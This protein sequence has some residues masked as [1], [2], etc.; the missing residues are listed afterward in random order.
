MDGES[1]N[2]VSILGLLGQKKTASSASTTAVNLEPL[3]P[4]RNNNNNNNNKQSNPVDTNNLYNYQGMAASV[5]NVEN[6]HHSLNDSSGKYVYGTNDSSNESTI[7]QSK[8]LKKSVVPSPNINLVLDSNYTPPVNKDGNPIFRKKS[9]HYQ[10]LI[11]MCNAKGW[12]EQLP[13]T[14]HDPDLQ[15]FCELTGFDRPQ[16]NRKFQEYRKSQWIP[17]KAKQRRQKLQL[18]KKVEL[19]VKEHQ[20]RRDKLKKKIQLADTIM[21]VFQNVDEAMEKAQKEPYVE[22]PKTAKRTKSNSETQQLKST[23]QPRTNVALDDKAV[24]EDK[25]LVA[26]LSPLPFTAEIEE[27]QHQQQQQ[28]LKALNLETEASLLLPPPPPTSPIEATSSTFSDKS[29]LQTLEL[30]DTEM[31]Q[32]H[33]NDDPLQLLILDRNSSWSSATSLT[34]QP[35]NLKQFSTEAE[36]KD[37]TMIQK[38]A[39]LSPNPP[40]DNADQPPP[41]S[42]VSPPL[43]PR[44]MAYFT[45]QQL[46]LHQSLYQ[47]QYQH[48][49]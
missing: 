36:Q 49:P 30:H 39:S 47:D 37:S 1:N 43:S 3:S 20:Q 25:P 19:A 5:D 48:Q 32:S 42:P 45:S 28:P 41:T 16:V 9:P 27:W 14:K 4:S 26:Q 34:L 33:D 24:A 31:P 15:K 40:D 38:P 23:K 17:T 46:H 35:P 8:N 29:L 44:T 22:I 13:T 18:K 2:D 10:T 6:N 7:E 11:D 12:T 21:E